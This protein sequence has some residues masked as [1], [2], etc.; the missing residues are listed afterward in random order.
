MNATHV[1]SL[2]GVYNVEVTI[3]YQGKSAKIKT[4]III[5]DRPFMSLGGERYLCDNR[6]IVISPGDNFISY[7]WHD[8]SS[9]SY[10]IVDKPGKYWLTVS[11]GIC[12]A[13]DTLNIMECSELWMPNAFTP[14]GDGINDIFYVKGVKI[15]Q[16]EMYIYN[17]WGVLIFESKDI[18]KGWD[19]TYKGKACKQGVYICLIKLKAEGIL[20]NRGSRSIH[21]GNVLLLR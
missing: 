13:T 16:I 20:S 1:F 14:D 5:V 9:K 12:T 6:S 2:T 19:G 18:N 15:D 4:T 7:L 10:F 17:N 3:Y 21:K 8:G 11:D